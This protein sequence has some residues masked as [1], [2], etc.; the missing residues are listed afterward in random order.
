MLREPWARHVFYFIGSLLNSDDLE[1]VCATK[2]KMTFVLCNINSSKPDDDDDANI[3]R[4]ATFTRQCPR[5]PL[6]LVVLRVNKLKVA[7]NLGLPRSWCFAL[8]SLKTSLAA[9][10]SLCPGVSTL[11]LNLVLRNVARPPPYTS[12]GRAAVARKVHGVDVLCH[13]RLDAR[14]VLRGQDVSGSCVRVRQSWCT[15]IGRAVPRDGPDRA[16]SLADET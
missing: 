7:S 2:S 9:T 10:N 5:A 6:R 8:N 16:Q 4:A 15:I 3:L 12:D 13:E 14:P 11:V 1:R